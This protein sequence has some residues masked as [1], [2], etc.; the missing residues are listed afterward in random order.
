MTDTVASS[1]T[2]QSALDLIAYERA[3]RPDGHF[4]NRRVVCADGFKVSIQASK[5]HYANDSAPSGEK[6]P[7]WRSL[8]DETVYYPF[9]SFEIGHPGP[10][11]TEADVLALEECES[12]GVWAWVPRDAVA[13]LLDA[14]GGAVTWEPDNG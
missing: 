8:R 4:V 6:A 1:P 2:T 3:P 14:H 5:G 13:R 10:E 12:G 11:M 7:Y 9:T